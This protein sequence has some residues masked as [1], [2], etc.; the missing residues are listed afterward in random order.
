MADLATHR[1]TKPRFSPNKINLS[2]SFLKVKRPFV[3]MPKESDSPPITLKDIPSMLDFIFKKFFL[4]KSTLAAT[5]GATYAPNR[6][7]SFKYFSSASLP[8]FNTGISIAP[9][10]PIKRVAMA[11]FSAPSAIL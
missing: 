7:N 3:T 2:P 9:D 4:T 1:R 5:S 11:V 8:S 10:L 6:S